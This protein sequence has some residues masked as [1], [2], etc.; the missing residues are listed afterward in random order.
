LCGAFLAVLLVQPA[1]AQEFPDSTDDFW[2]KA[3]Q[4]IV[5]LRAVIR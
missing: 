1:A 2:A 5:A 4:L 3:K